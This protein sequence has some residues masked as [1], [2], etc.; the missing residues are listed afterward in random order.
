LIRFS[1]VWLPLLLGVTISA[2]GVWLVM[3]DVDPAQL[4][5]SLSA[6][7][8]RWVIVAVM[9]IGATFFSRAWRWAILLQPIRCRLSTLLAAMLAGQ[10]LTFLLPMRVGDV[11]RSVV[12]GR[13][14]GSSVERALGSVAIEKVWDWIALTA[15]VVIVALIVP[16]PDWFAGPARAFGAI[17]TLLIA[18]LAIVVSQRSRG[19][20]AIDRTLTRVP[21]RGWLLERLNRLLDGME[22]LRRRE[23]AWHAGIGSTV[24]WLLGVVANAAV[25]RAFGIDS[26]PAAMFLMAVLM[27]GVA[28]PPSIAALGIFEALTVLALGVFNVSYDTALA[29]GLTLHVVIFVPPVIAGS[30]LAV[31][32]SRAGR[33]LYRTAERA[34]VDA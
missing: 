20:R 21:F 31:W 13:A 1:S 14:P 8:Y 28:L 32:E 24:T 18:L 4:G 3:R 15:L 33:P 16:L 30:L 26:W 17:A 7:D 25:L 12:V 9:A 27:V 2:A 22:S 6:A 23:A 10:V 5:R 34:Q 19:L 11:V 29:I